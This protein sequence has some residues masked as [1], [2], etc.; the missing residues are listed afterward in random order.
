MWP[1]KRS[2]P[3]LETKMCLKHCKYH[4]F[5]WKHRFWGGGPPYIYIYLKLSR[6]FGTSPQD[7]VPQA[8][9]TSSLQTLTPCIQPK[10]KPRSYHK[11]CIHLPLWVR[12]GR[13][14]PICH[15]TTSWWRVAMDE[16]HTLDHS[17]RAS[18]NPLEGLHWGG[19]CAWNSSFFWHTEGSFFT[20][21]LSFKECCQPILPS[22]SPSSTTFVLKR[23]VSDSVMPLSWPQTSV[24]DPPVLVSVVGCASEKEKTENLMPFYVF[25]CG[26]CP[27]ACFL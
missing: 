2:F 1:P 27:W 19:F 15:P 26:S 3:N 9:Q 6:H 25:V 4:C 11:W 7:H 10:S 16:L 23:S 14:L 12:R 20:G 5:C 13:L 21:S 18:Q 22:P 17:L 24:W 8:Y